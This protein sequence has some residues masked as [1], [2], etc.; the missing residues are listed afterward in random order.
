MLARLNTIHGRQTSGAQ[1][2]KDE[3]EAWAFKCL[4]SDI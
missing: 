1:G 2:Q 3:M 4:K